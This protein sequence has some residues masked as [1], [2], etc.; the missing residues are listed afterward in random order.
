MYTSPAAA[1]HDRD[2]PEPAGEPREQFARLPRNARVLG[3]LDDRSQGPV[4]V[5]QDRAALGASAKGLEL[6]QAHEG[7]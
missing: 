1:G 7:V 6:R 5:G 2:Q 4:D 3:P